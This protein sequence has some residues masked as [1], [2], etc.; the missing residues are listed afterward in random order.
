MWELFTWQPYE[1][2][3]HAPVSEASKLIVPSPVITSLLSLLLGSYPKTKPPPLLSLHRP[4]GP[5]LGAPAP[6]GLLS[7]HMPY[8]VP[9]LQRG[10]LLHH[11]PP[12]HPGPRGLLGGRG[13]ILPSLKSSRPPLLSAPGGLRVYLFPLTQIFLGRFHEIYIYIGSGWF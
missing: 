13:A 6:R 4:P 2:C 3:V 7:S 10:P 8:G 5:S 12:Y 1:N 9:T 11:G